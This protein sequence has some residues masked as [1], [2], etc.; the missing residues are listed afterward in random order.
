MSK[1]T[2]YQVRRAV[3][4]FLHCRLGIRCGRYDYRNAVR[5]EN[6]LRE[7]FARYTTSNLV[8]TTPEAFEK[9]EYIEDLGTDTQLHSELWQMVK[10][11]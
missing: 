10:T 1:G 2:S 8:G 4:R 6:H 7:L 5:L 3:A 9:L 11:R